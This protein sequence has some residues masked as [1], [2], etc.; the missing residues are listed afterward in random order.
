MNF[1]ILLASITGILSS[2]NTLKTPGDAFMMKILHDDAIFDSFILS[3]VMS[4]K[5]MNSMLHAKGIP[6]EVSAK[7]YKKL[8][9]HWMYKILV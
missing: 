5:E 7:L 8:L 6:L 9:E 2:K 3:G 4:R 1:W